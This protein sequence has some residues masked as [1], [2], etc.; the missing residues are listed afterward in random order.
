MLHDIRVVYRDLIERQS[1]G[2]K[3][4]ETGRRKTGEGKRRGY[5]FKH[6]FNITD[7]IIPIGFF[8]H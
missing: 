1:E 4:R 5:N 2:E 8:A 7:S 6:F 3:W